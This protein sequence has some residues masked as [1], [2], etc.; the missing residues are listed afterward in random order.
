MASVAKRPDGRWRARYRDEAG[1][2]HARHFDRK[3]AAQ[4]WLDG[5]TAALVRGEHVDPTAGAV[6]FAA[7]YAEWSARQVWAPRTLD[8][9]NLAARSVPFADQPLR[10][11]RRSHLEAWIKAMTARGLAPGT[12][13]TRVQNVRGVLRG[14]VADRLIPRDPSEGV[15]L[16]RRRRAE[17][18][19][20]LPTPTE[21]RALL[22]AADE[23]F[24][25]FLGLCA[26][27]GLRLGEAAAVQVGDV[28]FLRRTLRVARQ[29]QRAGGGEVDV[30]LPK[31]GS[32]RTVFLAPSLVDLLASSCPREGWLF[33]ALGGGPVTANMWTRAGERPSLG[34]VWPACGC[35][36]CGT[37]TP[38]A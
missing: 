31:S 1:R 6:T 32:E 10:A 5:I 21:V 11:L 28:D 8:A 16:P 13:H 4:R 34:R 19:M 7:F 26:F 14:A 36:I 27:A 23:S 33:P 18:A 24:R 9:M 17:A 30:R 20:R 35:T 25:P 12:V 29:V 15:R 37:S 22:E 3:I 38:R 2:E